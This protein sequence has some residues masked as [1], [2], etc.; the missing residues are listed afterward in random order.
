MADFVNCPQ[1]G[2]GALNL[3]HYE[4]MIVVTPEH[5]L[6]TMRCPQCDATVSSLRPI[7]QD[8]RDEVQ[9]AAIE[10]GAGMGRSL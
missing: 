5:A 7:P 8:M 1:C 9:F 2:S 3:H 4:S 10:V 6:F